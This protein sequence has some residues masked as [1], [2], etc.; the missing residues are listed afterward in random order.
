[1][2]EFGK[3]FNM[4]SVW[5]WIT[6]VKPYSIK[7]LGEWRDWIGKTA[8]DLKLLDK[9]HSGYRVKVYGS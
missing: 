4:E 5:I 8:A 3:T 6:N 7:D 1:M 9:K 2:F